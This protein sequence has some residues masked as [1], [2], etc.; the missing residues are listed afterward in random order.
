MIPGGPA[1]AMAKVAALLPPLAAGGKPAAIAVMSD[2]APLP[3]DFF[4][5][6][7]N[8]GIPVFRSPERALRA[9]AHATWYGRALGGGAAGMHEPPIA[10]VDL[11]A[12]AGALSEHAGKHIARELGIAVPRG[13]L[14]Q[15]LDAARRAAPAIG[16]PLV[17]K[18]QAPTLTHKTEAGG[19][20]TGIA[21]ADALAAAWRRLHDNIAAARPGQ[22]LDGV[23]V[24]AMAPAGIDMVVGARRDPDWGPVVMAGLGGIWVEA[25]QDVRLM[26]ADLPRQTI[27]EELA[28]LK[29]APLLH[30]AR[31]R[32]AADMQALVEVIAAV[33]ALMRLEPRVCEIDINPLRIYAK[34]QGA[35]ALDVLVVLD[36]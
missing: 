18:A 5:A 17:L 35:L 10:A 1:A 19:V 14:V 4:P 11:P 24:E 27:A 2:E 20:I 25:L 31:G 32:P 3:A 7:R 8:Q 28:Q 15:N 30:G 13:A 26:P 29:A 34:G 33:S 12:Q 6:F 16:Y 21:D 22:E 9:M 36:G 23:L